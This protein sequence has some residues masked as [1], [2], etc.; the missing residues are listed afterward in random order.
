[1]NEYQERAQS[2]RNAR[3]AAGRYKRPTKAQ[4]AA[5]A[6]L[7]QRDGLTLLTAQ[8][9]TLLATHPHLAASQ[10]AMYAAMA[11]SAVTA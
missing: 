1:M 6:K 2:T 4:E 8:E 11:E 10:K 9:L 7:M 5:F 3:Q